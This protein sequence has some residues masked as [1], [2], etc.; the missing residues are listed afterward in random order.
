MCPGRGGLPGT[1]AALAPVTARAGGRQPFAPGYKSFTCDLRSS[2]RP[3][4]GRRAGN[5]GWW[6]GHPS[7]RVLGSNPPPPLSLRPTVPLPLW[8]LYLLV[9][10]RAGLGRRPSAARREEEEGWGEAMPE[11]C[12]MWERREGETLSLPLPAAAG[13]PSRRSPPDTHRPAR[14]RDGAAATERASLGVSIPTATP[15]LPPPPPPPPVSGV[16][17]ERVPMAFPPRS[18]LPPP[19][20]L[21][22][23][24]AGGRRSRAKGQHA[25]GARA[26]EA[27]RKARER[28]RQ[29]GRQ[30][31]PPVML[32]ELFFQAACVSLVLPGGQGR[33]YPARKKPASFAVER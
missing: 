6:W 23:A 10:P 20:A 29:G 8:P 4:E 18:R 25:V 26:A 22:S 27:G 31:E 14:N 11:L 19:P 16:G 21:F 7:V 28:G 3:G 9:G 2:P 33:V 30:P 24:T 13:T 17:G 5:G 32:V 15:C 12:Q 1:S